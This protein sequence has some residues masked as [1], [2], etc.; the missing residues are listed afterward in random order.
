MLH[1]YAAFVFFVWSLISHK[2]EKLQNKNQQLI[3]EV[4]KSAFLAV[5]SI[6]FYI[7]IFFFLSCRAPSPR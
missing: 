6:I 3:V 2:D 5:G 4:N 7:L 1:I